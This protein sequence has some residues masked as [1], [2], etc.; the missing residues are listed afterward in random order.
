M[1]NRDGFVKILD[2]GLAKLAAPAAEGGSQLAT[3][4]GPGTRPGHGPGDGRLHVPRAGERR[5][6]RLPLGPV[7]ARLDPLRDGDGQA[8]LPEEDRGRDALGDHPRRPG[9]DDRREP[10]GAGAAAL[11]RRALPRQGAGEPVRRDPRPRARPQADARPSLGDL[12]RDVRRGEARR[13]AGARWWAA[14]LAALLAVGVADRPR[15]GGAAAA[16]PKRRRLLAPDLR[17]GPRGRAELFSRRQ[18]PRLHDRRAGKP[19]RGGAVA[20]GRRA[21]PHRGDRRRRGAA[22]LV[23]RTARG[24]PSCPLGTTEGVW[25]R[26]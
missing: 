22:G 14:G 25:P 23:S 18:V 21:H 26:R 15:R 9:A 5:A 16:A 7:L 24:S 1:V 12:P 4:A 11:D 13:R 8:R 17:P 19:R 3:L 10:A 6:G 2:F 20:L